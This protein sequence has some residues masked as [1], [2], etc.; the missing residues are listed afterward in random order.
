MTKSDPLWKKRAK[1]KHL[2]GL[3]WGD[4]MAMLAAQ[5]GRCRICD[6][7]M[8]MPRVDHCHR[9]SKVRGLLCHNCNVALGHF[10][11]SPTLL[12]RAIEYL[13]R[14]SEPIDVNTSGSGQC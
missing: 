6:D 11:D 14:A 12:A 10:R 8:T 3:R 2:Y 7:V 5:G 9:T 1:L 13:T 4:F